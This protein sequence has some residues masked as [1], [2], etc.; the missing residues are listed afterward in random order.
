MSSILHL[1]SAMRSNFGT[2]SLC[3]AHSPTL[4]HA[5]R[6]QPLPGRNP[7]AVRFRAVHKGKTRPVTPLRG[8]IIK[9]PT[10]GYQPH[11]PDPF[12]TD[13]DEEDFRY[14]S[15]YILV[16]RRRHRFVRVF[17]FG[18]LLGYFTGP[19]RPEVSQLMLLETLKRHC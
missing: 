14:T 10:P 18:A 13:T 17:L 1:R 6:L 15:E 4:Y 11:S 12:D 7:N 16:E 8:K 2:L 19:T 3:L 9:K 5:R